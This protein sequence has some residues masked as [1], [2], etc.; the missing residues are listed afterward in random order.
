MAFL[1]LGHEQSA[2]LLCVSS[3]VAAHNSKHQ[4]LL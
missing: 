3:Q 1:P 2:M 4:S